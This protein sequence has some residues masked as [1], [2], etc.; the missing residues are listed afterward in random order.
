MTGDQK[1]GILRTGRLILVRHGQTA[2][3]RERRMQGHLDAPLD[4]TGRAQ[5]HQLALHFRAQG[6]TAPSIHSSDL[7]RAAATAQALH[8]ELGGT[9][10]Q[11]PSLREI[12]MGAWE[13]RLYSDLQTQQAELFSRFWGGDA[14]CLAPGGE[15]P[16]ATGERVLRHTLAHWPQAGKT[17]V[18]VSHGIAI[19]AL[20]SRLLGLDY[21]TGWRS[22]AL[23]HRNTAYSVLDVDPRNHSVLRSELA[24]A[25]HLD[26]LEAVL[27]P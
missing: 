17:L 9:L 24:Q 25:G 5:A 12:H 27:T 20:L 19:G 1:D 16:H 13:G 6:V 7:A 21:Q 11:Y 14:H 4:D 15:T 8:R 18:L 3:N 2:H 22:R 10:L 23:E 26:S